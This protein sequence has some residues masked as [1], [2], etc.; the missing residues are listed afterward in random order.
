MQYYADNTLTKFTTRLQKVLTLQGEWEIGLCEI[1]FT[2][3]WFNVM[4]HEGHAIVIACSECYNKGPPPPSA[5]VL[6]NNVY[7]F[8]AHLPHGH[9]ET[10]ETLLESIN[11]SIQTR[12][13]WVKEK[14]TSAGP[15]RSNIPIPIFKYNLLTRRAY[16]TLHRM[17][18]VTL[19]ESLIRL[20][21]FNKKSRTLIPSPAEEYTTIFG[22]RPIDM[23]IGLQHLFV[24][25]DIAEDVP[26]GD[27]CAPLLRI[28]NAEGKHGHTIHRIYDRPRY[29]PL[30][31]KHF[32]S[33]T[34]DIRDDAGQAVPFE[35]GKVVVTLHLK[36]AKQSYFLQ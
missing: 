7:E 22:K 20:L 4:E 8:S 27:T 5:K 36:Q 33:I 32:D 21:G 12:L 17:F 28:V 19:S 9:Y 10:V 30:H 3:S 29:I 13:A 1:A 35:Y 25:T 11:N 16:V 34:I 15:L 6:D 26:V 2:R 14:L 24:Y 23:Q 18:T 31:K